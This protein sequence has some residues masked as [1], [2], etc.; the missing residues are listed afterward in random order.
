MPGKV[1]QEV[2]LIDGDQLKQQSLE[3]CPI[4]REAAL[5][6][7]L[8]AEV[9]TGYPGL[10]VF[11]VANESNIGEFWGIS[12]YVDIE[13]L[14]SE[15]NNRI[16]RIGQ[17]L[18]KHSTPRVILP[19][20]VMKFD[21]RTGRYYVERSD[22]EAMEVSPDQ[23][24]NLPRYLVWDA[25][26]DAA[27]QELELLERYIMVSS[28]T[29]PA[30]LGL[31]KGGV[32]ESGRALKFRLLRTLSKVG[33]TRS[34]FD[35]ALKGALF[36]AQVLAIKFGTGAEIGSITAAEPVILGWPDGLPEDVDGNVQREAVAVGAE[37]SSRFS[38]I[39][40]IYG[41]TKEQTYAEITRIRDEQA[42]IESPD[43]TLMT[44][45][46]LSQFAQS[47]QFDQTAQ[48]SFGLSDDALAQRD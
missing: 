13:R 9:D 25:K 4:T 6:G 8:M 46:Q 40:R 23:A 1:Y 10:L 20:G 41:L 35:A 34:Y 2:Y 43:S 37:L 17:T 44:D 22:L 11:H 27:F 31:E 42:L 29:S 47:N 16:S 36:A 32:A 7:D 21:N 39:Q 48:S 26:L 12:D 24:G 18:D 19:P 38:S 5:L 15:L 33:R 28:S 14:N 3:S 45:S 30:A